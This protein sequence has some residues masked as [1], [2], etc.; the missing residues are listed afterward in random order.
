MLRRTVPFRVH[1]FVSLRKVYDPSFHANFHTSDTGFLQDL[2]TKAYPEDPFSPV[3]KYHSLAGNRYVVSAPVTVQDK[4][5]R[6]PFII[7]T[8]APWT[9]LHPLA[10]QKFG[11]ED[12]SAITKEVLKR[13]QI[14][15]LKS[16]EGV[17]LNQEGTCSSFHNI[18]KKQDQQHANAITNLSYLNVLG[19]DYISY[20][21]RDLP[22]FLTSNFYRIQPPIKD[23]LVTNGTATTAVTPKAPLVVY[24]KKAIKAEFPELCKGIPSYHI[25][26]RDPNNNNQVMGDTDPLHA[27]I[28]YVFEVPVAE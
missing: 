19:T 17:Q 12:P 5:L 1:E 27:N 24:L 26:L 9:M 13:V 14:G 23:V 11:I 8:G 3:R 20:V 15:K 28:E 4:C 22:E 21:I 2:Y 10:F 7:D 18:N 16:M 6:V 25:I